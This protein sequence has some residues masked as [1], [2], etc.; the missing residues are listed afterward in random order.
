ME[1]IENKFYTRVRIDKFACLV[2]IDNF[3][4]NL[5]SEYL[6]EKLGLTIV[7]HLLPYEMKHYG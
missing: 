7:N 4:C 5:I 2:A 6:V 3:C 1:K